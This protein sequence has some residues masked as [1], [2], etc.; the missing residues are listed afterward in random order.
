MTNFNVHHAGSQKGRLEGMQGI[1]LSKNPSGFIMFLT[2]EEASE[3]IDVLY[4][5]IPRNSRVDVIGQN[6]N[7][8]L[9]YPK[10]E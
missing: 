8:G 3:L 9:H 2:Y 10:D 1:F 4:S 5:A 7:D 6:G